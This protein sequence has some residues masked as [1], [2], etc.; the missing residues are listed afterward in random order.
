M[1]YGTHG[2]AQKFVQNCFPSAIVKFTKRVK[3]NILICTLT[4]CTI[5]FGQYGMECIV[6]H[7]NPIVNNALVDEHFINATPREW[8]N[9]SR[10][11]LAT[12]HYIH[13]RVDKH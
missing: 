10:K 7:I 12:H 1:A 8:C 6:L 3:N 4:Y 13:S 9:S 2:Q 5:P 11:L